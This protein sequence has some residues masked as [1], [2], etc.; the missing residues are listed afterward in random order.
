MG[1]FFRIDNYFFEISNYDVSL[2][3]KGQ[4]RRSRS[5]KLHTDYTSRYYTFDITIEG[6]N[7][8]QHNNLLYLLYKCLP[9][10]GE[11]ETLSFSDDNDITDKEVIIPV[12]G[13]SFERENGKKIS[14]VWNL[15]LEEVI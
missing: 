12:D 1:K 8:E 4:S 3:Y 7:K 15:T 5:G 9:E 14:Y 10:E 2:N 13:F 6:V 11:G